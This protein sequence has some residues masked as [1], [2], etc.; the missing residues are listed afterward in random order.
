MINILTVSPEYCI[1]VWVCENPECECDLEEAMA[2]VPADWYQDNGTPQC[3]CGTDMT[4][5]ET[6]VEIEA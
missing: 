3:P 5:R 2:E 6:Y 4:Y 1:S